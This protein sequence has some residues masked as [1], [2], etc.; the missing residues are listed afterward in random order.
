MVVIDWPVEVGALFEMGGLIVRCVCGAR[1][2]NG[3]ARASRKRE[4]IVRPQPG[5][6]V[7][8]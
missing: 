7:K 2:G 5:L 6:T 3:A 4:G 1:H 8:S